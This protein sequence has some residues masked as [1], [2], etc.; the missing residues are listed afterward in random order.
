MLCYNPRQ[1]QTVLASFSLSGRDP[2]LIIVRPGSLFN[3]SGPIK[4]KDF[5]VGLNN[6]R[7]PRETFHNSGAFPF[8]NKGELDP[9]GLRIPALILVY[10][11]TTH[12]IRCGV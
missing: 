11:G 8:F 3:S 4:K 7:V 10:G 12:S 2:E 1:L 5:D 9:G 6:N